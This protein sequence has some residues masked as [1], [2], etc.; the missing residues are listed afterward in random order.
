MK[1]KSFLIFLPGKVNFFSKKNI[2]KIKKNL[3]SK[4]N[5]AKSLFYY[6][7]AQ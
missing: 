1:K 4:V 6:T 2:D 3:N 7:F 5:F